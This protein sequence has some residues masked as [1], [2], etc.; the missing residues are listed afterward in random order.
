MPE[1]RIFTAARA[2]AELISYLHVG[3]A[4]GAIIPGNYASLYC[5]AERG[6]EITQPQLLPLPGG[7]LVPLGY[8][9]V[10]GTPGV[11]WGP[12]AVP[13]DLLGPLGVT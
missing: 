12:M 6:L 10:F 1:S 9:G 4:Q 5:A 13:W 2:T 11:P 3:K 7:P 8:V